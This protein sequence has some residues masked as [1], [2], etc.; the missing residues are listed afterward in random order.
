MRL[1]EFWLAVADE[2]GEEYGRVISRDLVL[3]DIGGLTAE[4]GIRDGVATRQIW[5]A[6][7]KAM[8]VPRERWHGVGQ[9]EPRPGR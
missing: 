1:S 6:L 8:D 3:G 2:F 9:R 4:Q 5:L 7:C